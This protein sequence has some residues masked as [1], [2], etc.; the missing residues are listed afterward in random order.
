MYLC[1]EEGIPI[2]EIVDMYGAVAYIDPANPY[3]ITAAAANING[4]KLQVFPGEQV[5][6]RCNKDGKHVGKGQITKIDKERYT[7]YVN[8]G[9]FVSNENVSIYRN[10]DYQQTSRIGRGN[11]NK[12]GLTPLAGD[13][14]LVKT[15]VS[16]GETVEKGVLLYETIEG[17]FAPGCTDMNQIKSD[18]SGIVAS[19]L[20][21]D[22]EILTENIASTGSI[23]SLQNQRVEV[24]FAEIYPDENKR[25]VAYAPEGMVGYFRENDVVSI[26]L[27]YAEDPTVQIY[28]LV[29]KISKIPVADSNSLDSVYTV[30]ITI[31]GQQELFY[32]MNVVVTATN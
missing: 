32:G 26:S 8:E 6:L 27:N 9:E 2:S 23:D 20:L 25:I 14:Y 11:I 3:T 18:V 13:G 12:A 15:Y 21:S 7:V 1:G 19:I 16:S 10:E 28:G 24:A 5:F 31:T 17:S 30:T 4:V 29:E 22:N